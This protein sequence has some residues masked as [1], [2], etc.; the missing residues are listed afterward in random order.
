[1]QNRIYAADN[2]KGTRLWS[3]VAIAI[4]AM[5]IA[6]FLA[7]FT[8]NIPCGI[9]VLLEAA[10][11]TFVLAALEKK[12]TASQIFHAAAVIVF[13]LSVMINLDGIRRAIINSLNV[14]IEY[15]NAAF[16]T[17]HVT[18]GAQSASAM[19]FIALY[20][21]LTAIAVMLV[22][23]TVRKRNV[24]M[25]TL[26]AFV[27]LA[28]ALTLKVNALAIILPLTV[29][30]WAGCWSVCS[31]GNVKAVMY[32]IAGMAA[33]CAVGAL[34]LTLTGFNG[35]DA[36]DDLHEDV[37]QAVHKFRYGADSLPKGD[38]FKADTMLDGEGEMLRVTFKEPQSVYLKGFTGGSFR[39][40]VW[41]PYEEDTYLGEWGGMLDYFAVSRFGPNNIYAQYSEADGNEEEPNIIAV[42]NT[43][44]DRS[45]VYL[46]FTAS[47]IE[48]IGAYSYRD[49][50]IRPGKF[51]GADKYSFAN[52]ETDKKP[53][54][55]TAASWVSG[56]DNEEQS[57][58]LKKENVYRAFVKDTYLDIDEKTK[59]EIDEV[60]FKDFETDKEDVGVY[61]I[62]TR[63][64]SILKLVATY[65]P[66]P[67]EPED[68]DFIG[69]FLASYRKGNSAYFATTAVM[70][71]RAAGIPARYAEGYYVSDTDVENLN[72][73]DK[74]SVS[75]S[76]KNAHAWVEI[77]RD[78]MG[79]VSIEVTPGFYVESA[80]DMEV[81]DIS[82]DAELAGGGKNGSEQ[83]TGSLSMYSPEKATRPEDRMSSS[84]RITLILICLLTIAAM[85]MYIRYLVLIY[86]KNKRIYAESTDDTANYM[87]MYICAALA[88]DGVEANPDNAVAL[89]RDILKKYP[90]FT[91]YEID[92]V[93]SLI[94]RSSYG[95]ARL[96]EHELRT[97]R[98][99]IEK[100]S[101][102]VYQGKSFFRKIVL[103]YVKV[104]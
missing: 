66:S 103:R 12:P 35:I 3:S 98:I 55:L 40:N 101:A 41:V 5:G 59:S 89:K 74:N 27:V 95:G 42:E 86:L 36:L 37:N 77:Y 8:G 28:I 13:A 48:N 49:L 72:M 75:L 30:G 87:M 25:L 43:G 68:K 62:T 9:F 88:A 85:I 100:L 67:V 46:P 16:S 83:Y 15:S 38:L 6:A 52:V 78:G 93:T 17:D 96:R 34:L 61:T 104:I 79:W 63:I 64:R 76:G 29:M 31:A 91:K 84:L 94:S 92:R 73:T 69:W 1:M 56:S 80:E 70:A 21:I 47:V 65:T 50:G 2:T 82:K 22:N 102:Q 19:D 32:I 11:L 20:A 33:A 45:Y 39:E 24:I 53:E 51:F 97:I 23:H 4:L 58:Y 26:I 57:E 54:L 18:L 10:V 99:F 14:V 71:Y 60:F 7:S 90:V 44:A 81:I